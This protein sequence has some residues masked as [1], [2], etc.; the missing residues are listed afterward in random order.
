MYT[1]IVLY[2]YIYSKYASGFITTNALLVICWYMYCTVYAMYY[3]IYILYVASSV[4]FHI[5]S[6][7]VI[8][9]IFVC[10]AFFLSL[11]LSFIIM[12]MMLMLLLIVM[13]VIIM[14]IVIVMIAII[15][16]TENS[17]E[18]TDFERGN[19]RSKAI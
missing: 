11:S 12:V 18:S 2:I 9:F 16:E 4:Y 15:S 3:T 7:L 8:I 1:S 19:W 5:A 14:I 6:E 13:I 10:C 17:I